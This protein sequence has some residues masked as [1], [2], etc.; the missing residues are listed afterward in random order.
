M[1]SRDQALQDPIDLE[2]YHVVRCG[3]GG[4]G[5][6]TGSQSDPVVGAGLNS[7]DWFGAE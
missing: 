4:G 1:G 3:G 5:A 2:K 6:L 7:V